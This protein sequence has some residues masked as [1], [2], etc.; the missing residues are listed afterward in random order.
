MREERERSSAWRIC[1]KCLVSTATR[2]LQRSKSHFR[3]AKT[4][5]PDLHPRDVMAEERFKAIQSRI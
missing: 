2:V 3:L 5:H 4:Y 1:T